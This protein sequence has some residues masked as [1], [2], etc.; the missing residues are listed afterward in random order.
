MHN[1][2]TAPEER[3]IVSFTLYRQ[4]QSALFIPPFLP[5]QLWGDDG[6]TIA[7]KLWR[8]LTARHGKQTSL[9]RLSALPLITI[10][11]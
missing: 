3:N 7:A 1:C 8:A 11:Q 9:M 6:K 4:D 5:L 2:P 10:N